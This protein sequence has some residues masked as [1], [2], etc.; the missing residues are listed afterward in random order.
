MRIIQNQLISSACETFADAPL[1][2]SRS[3]TICSTGSSAATHASSTASTSPNPITMVTSNE[4]HHIESGQ[5]VN[6]LLDR[7]VSHTANSMLTAELKSSHS[8]RSESFS[9]LHQLQDCKEE[10]MNLLNLKYPSAYS[11]NVKGL[12]EE[13]ADNVEKTLKDLISAA[14]KVNAG[15]PH[16]IRR[17]IIDHDNAVIATPCHAKT[18]VNIPAVTSDTSLQAVSSSTL[19]NS[20]SSSSRSTQNFQDVL[21]IQ[22][23]SSTHMLHRAFS[24]LEHQLHQERKEASMKHQPVDKEVAVCKKNLSQDYIKEFRNSLG[25][26][27]AH[28][29]PVRSMEETNY[30]FEQ[31]LQELDDSHYLCNEQSNEGNQTVGHQYLSMDPSVNL[32]SHTS[33]SSHYVPTSCDLTANDVFTKIHCTKSPDSV[34]S[35]DLASH[36]P[37]SHD[38]TASNDTVS[39]V[40]TVEC[41]ASSTNDQDDHYRHSSMATVTIPYDMAEDEPGATALKQLVTISSNDECLGRI[42]AHVCLPA[43]SSKLLQLSQWQCSSAGLLSNMAALFYNLFEVVIS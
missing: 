39:I 25:L 33:S 37:A 20:D 7:V 34:A 28:N 16:L 24:N 29:L 15:K 19:M 1:K 41:A 27:A 32:P 43:F 31:I 22:D 10:K 4:Q 3:A 2:V 11:L 35:Y 38:I 8:K 6:E 26:P 30:L 42:V 23:T 17:T 40:T 9:N 21:N 12:V 36:D 18:T 14:S 13:S 5:M